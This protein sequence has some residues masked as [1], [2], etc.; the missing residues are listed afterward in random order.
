[1]TRLFVVRHCETDGNV[2]RIYQGLIDLD[3]NDLGKKQ[4]Q[5]LKNRFQKIALD[6][7]YTS[8][9]LRAKKTAF[10]IK[11]AKEIPLL[12]NSGLIELSGGVYEGLT[13][14]QIG[15]K[16]PEFKEIWN[17]RP[18]DFNP[19]NGESMKTAYNRIWSC[20]TEIAKENEGK[21]IAVVTHGAV[22]RCLNCKLLK[23]DIMSLNEVAFGENTSVSLLEFDNSF[24]CR[25]IYYNNAEHLTKE[26]KNHKAKVPM[27]ENR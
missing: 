16:Y 6:K 24:N 18:W 1:M 26:L 8:P 14:K 7:V 19:E 17:N 25:L 3:I 4:L 23:N 10:A 11:G 15:E 21:T 22:L 2:N 20:V 12:E 27:E 5:A 13:Y 9:L